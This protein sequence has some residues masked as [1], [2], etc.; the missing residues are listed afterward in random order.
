[1]NHAT[2]W[3]TNLLRRT[4]PLILVLVLSSIP[5]AQAQDPAAEPLTATVDI[6]NRNVQLMKAGT[7]RWLNITIESV[8]ARGDRIRTD[9]NGAAFVTWFEDGSTVELGPSTEI[10]IEDLA[11]T[12]DSF[13]I[14]TSLIQGSIFSNITRLLD[15]EAGYEV[16]LPNVSA[17]VRG[18]RFGS[19]VGPDLESVVIVT[20]GT[21]NVASYDDPDLN[22]DVEEGNGLVVASDGTFGDPVDIDDI[23]EDYPDFVE[24]MLDF[25]ERIQEAEEAE[26]DDADDDT[27][28]GETGATLDNNDGGPPPNA[29]PAQDN[30]GQGD[31]NRS[32]TGEMQST[33]GGTGDGSS[34]G[35]GP[36]GQNRG[37]GP[38]NK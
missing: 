29:P 5:T 31:D 25:E 24:A 38:P 22:V 8:V 35:G 34:G 12:S 3:L 14:Q 20:E 19:L 11:E 10:V 7:T 37:G 1:M 32:D 4:L 17:T 18:T 15:A 2:D 30:P 21:V 27:D 23:A 6:I 33:G 16:L 9:D 36:P 13:F 26:E 28:N